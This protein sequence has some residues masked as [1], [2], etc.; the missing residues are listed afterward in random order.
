MY[1]YIYVYIYIYIYIYEKQG[2][3]FF[4]IQYQCNK[5]TMNIYQYKFYFITFIIL[6]DNDTN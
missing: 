6:T 4:V 5:F 2:K 1:I 3:V